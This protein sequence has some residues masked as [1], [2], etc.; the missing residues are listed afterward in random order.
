MKSMTVYIASHFTH[1][2]MHPES[3]HGYG[4]WIINPN[5]KKK[6]KLPSYIIIMSMPKFNP[7]SSETITSPVGH[8]VLS[9]TGPDSVLIPDP[10]LGH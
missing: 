8:N 9:I 1:M 7:F 2:K 6:K 10:V 5:K 4:I 3:I